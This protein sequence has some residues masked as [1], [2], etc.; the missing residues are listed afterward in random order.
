VGL[1]RVLF[2]E[3]K[4]FLEAKAAG[5]KSATPAEFWAETKKMLAQEW[6]MSIYCIILMTWV[7]SHLKLFK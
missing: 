4:Q 6:R 5:K 7:S 1:V 2:P 3:S